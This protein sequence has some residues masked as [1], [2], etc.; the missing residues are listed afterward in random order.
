MKIRAQL[1]S[2]ENSKWCLILFLQCYLQ[3]LVN[4]FKRARAEFFLCS[5]STKDE[6]IVYITQT[7]DS[8]DEFLFDFYKS[9]GTHIYSKKFTIEGID[10]SNGYID[11]QISPNGKFILFKVKSSKQ[12]IV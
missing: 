9:N 11:L 10:F 6:Y 1:E 3:F 2:R 5:H 4:K 8:I 12:A 7:V